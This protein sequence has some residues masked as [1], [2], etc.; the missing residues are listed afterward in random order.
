MNLL[1]VYT[2]ILIVE[3]KGEIDLA[4]N[5]I[6]FGLYVLVYVGTTTTIKISS[7]PYIALKSSNNLRVS[8]FMSFF[9]GKILHRYI[10]EEIPIDT[11]VIMWV[12]KLAGEENQP[13]MDDRHPLFEWSPGHNIDDNEQLIM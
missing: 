12:E 7:V 13:K 5:R 1:D 9:T 10:W 2:S 4:Q 6:D 3:G 8:Y 11:D